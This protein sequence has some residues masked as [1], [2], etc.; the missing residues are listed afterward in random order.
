[1][2]PTFGTSHHA[3]EESYGFYNTISNFANNGFVVQS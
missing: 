1:L 3:Q 2:T